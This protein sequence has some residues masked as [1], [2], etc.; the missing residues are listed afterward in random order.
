MLWCSILLVLFGS[1]SWC[2]GSVAGQRE[3]QQRRR[4]QNQPRL[5]RIPAAA[6]HDD[7]NRKDHPRRT[8]ADPSS[9]SSLLE[10][11]LELELELDT[12]YFSRRE[13]AQGLSSMSLSMSM[14]TSP[15][16]VP[17]PFATADA[18]T[19][20]IHVILEIGK[21][22]GEVI[23]FFEELIHGIEQQASQVD[24]TKIRI[25]VFD[26]KGNAT[27][28]A[29]QIAASA[30][31]ET[32]AAEDNY[33]ADGIITIDGNPAFTAALC[34]SI[35]TANAAGIPV[36]SKNLD[37]DE[38][39]EEGMTAW[40]QTQQSN[41][42]IAELVLAQAAQDTPVVVGPDGLP[43][44]TPV[45]YVNDLARGAS[46][47]NVV[48]ETYRKNY[49]WEQEFF[50]DQAASYNTSDDLEN[51]I[52]EELVAATTSPNATIQFVYAPWDY[53]ALTT[54]QAL[55]QLDSYD[56]DNSNDHDFTTTKVY[57]A[58][59]NTEDIE[60][61][62][63]PYSPWLATAGGHP[64]MIGAAILRMNLLQL[65]KAT[66]KE[67]VQMPS[68][69]FTQDFLRKEQVTNLDELLIAMPE[70]RMQDIASACWIEPL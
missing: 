47:R 46:A 63:A 23:V 4:R 24:D 14:S 36:V 26:A 70:L 16:T 59:I 39:G 56:D 43:G 55:Q 22:G 33:P 67:F 44:P 27:A 51:A 15:C 41:T 50:V 69:L 34:A 13:L 52:T 31:Q 48:W 32:T 62:I 9:S 25:S 12:P 1:S 30:S 64:A 3:P 37:C 17:R 8:N 2:W 58:D 60:A 45:G 61:M 20:D 42:A 40:V 66:T 6:S 29:A 18:M 65:A 11:E 54:V 28:M 19:I 57:G 7:D 49:Q 5:L 53:L 38:T 10:L 35:V 21:A 68:F